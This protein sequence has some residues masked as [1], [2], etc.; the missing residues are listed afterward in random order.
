MRKEDNELV[1]KEEERK[2]NS[3]RWILRL[4]YS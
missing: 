4:I 2:G 1:R 3:K